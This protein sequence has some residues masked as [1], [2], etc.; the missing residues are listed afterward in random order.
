MRLRL[1]AV[2]LAAVLGIV[3]A[4]AQF[5]NPGGADPGTVERAPGIPVPSQTNVQDRLF[6][7]LAAQGG[8]AEVELAKLAKQRSHNEAVAA[9][10]SQ[11]IEDHGKSNGRLMQLAKQMGVPLPSDLAADQKAL[12][13]ELSALD[14]GR[15]ETAYMRAQIV[16]HQKTVQLLLW[17]IASGES[18]DMQR[19]ATETLPTVL[20]HLELA[21]NLVQQLTGAV[22]P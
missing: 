12:Q 18:A 21:Q 15:F 22:A 9:F 20:H 3:P 1:S 6:A 11:M 14:Q 2:I 16:D 8:M 7:A 17:V 5:G 4:A 19:F 10:A 13:Q